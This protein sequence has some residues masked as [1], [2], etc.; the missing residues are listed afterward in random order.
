[1]L[2]LGQ[3]GR[4]PITLIRVVIQLGTLRLLLKIECCLLILR[5]NGLLRR[6]S[7]I[8]CLSFVVMY[9]L[10]HPVDVGLELFVIG[11]V[12]LTLVNPHAHLLELLDEVL[13]VPLVHLASFSLH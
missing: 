3:R 5:M 13:P 7:M 8:I 11:Q 12:Y 6:A 10:P 1:M 9:L 4:E 2:H